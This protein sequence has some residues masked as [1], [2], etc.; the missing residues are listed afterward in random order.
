MNLM[1]AESITFDEETGDVTFTFLNSAPS[2]DP[3]PVAFIAD[4]RVTLLLP[5]GVLSDRH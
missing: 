2:D 1:A 5:G 3:N 4:K